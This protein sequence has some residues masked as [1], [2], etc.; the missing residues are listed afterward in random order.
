MITDTFSM[1]SHLCRKSEEIIPYLIQIL[2]GKNNFQILIKSLNGN[3]ISKSR[4]CN[5][6]GNL[7]KH[8]DLFYESLKRNRQII[9]S[10]IKCCQIEELNVR[11]VI[12]K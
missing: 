5:L 3:A 9:E 7:M 4:C 11:K 6:I 1:F 12:T 2:K 8:N 10:L